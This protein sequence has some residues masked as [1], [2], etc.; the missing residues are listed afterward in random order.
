MIAERQ[1]AN[2]PDAALR[3]LLRVAAVGH[4]ENLASG[5]AIRLVARIVGRVEAAVGCRASMSSPAT[6]ANTRLSIALK[7]APISTCP[8]AAQIIDRLQSPTTDSGRG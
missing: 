4:T 2:F 7:S 1:I 5:D 6:Q 8:G 3:R